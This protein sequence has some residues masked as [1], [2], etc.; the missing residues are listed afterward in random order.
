MRCFERYCRFNVEIDLRI[1]LVM[2]FPEK[3]IESLV[4]KHPWNKVYDPQLLDIT[5]KFTDGTFLEKEV[6]DKFKNGVAYY[7]G[8]CQRMFDK[9]PKDDEYM[10]LHSLYYQTYKGDLTIY[11][12]SVY[13]C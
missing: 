10:K 1:V 2:L 12:E 13:F 8:H 11:H 6:I 5:V 4:I 7:T 3:K 9:I